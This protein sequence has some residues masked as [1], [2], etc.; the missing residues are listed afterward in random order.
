MAN[1]V[2]EVVELVPS[3][4]NALSSNPSTEK[5]KKP[6]INVIVHTFPKYLHH[7]YSQQLYAVLLTTSL[8]YYQTS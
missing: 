1:R 6:L 4:H 2:A 7:L 8:C 3:K 5:N